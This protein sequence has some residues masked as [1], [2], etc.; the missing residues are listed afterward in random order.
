MD[1]LP[2]RKAIHYWILAKDVGII[3][4][5]DTLLDAVSYFNIDHELT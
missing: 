3:D 4:K 5:N 2:T 1:R